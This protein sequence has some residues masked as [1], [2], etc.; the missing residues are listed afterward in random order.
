MGGLGS[1][2]QGSLPVIENGLQLDLRRM[3]RH[4]QF[5]PDAHLANGKLVWSYTHSGEQ[6]ANIGYSYCSTG[7]HPWFRVKYTSTP[8]GGE[9]I[10]V[11]EQFDLERFPQPFGG[12]RWY[13]I[14]PETGKRAQ[15]L[16]SP[17]GA[18]RFRSR[19]GFRVPLQYR[20]QCE[21]PTSRLIG[22]MHKVA[23]KILDAGTP[24]WRKKYRTWDFP[25]KP[26]GMHWRTY[27][28]LQER[29]EYYETASWAG[30]GS[31]L[32]LFG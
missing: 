11:D 15:C 30:I 31:R 14:C 29:W 20:S 17:P 10:S 25:P 6:I 22:Q 23:Y 16:Y 19:H 5:L 18:T 9:P 1:G 21:D 8:R 28:R 26:P 32:K 24:E 2:R 3:R 13:F 27:N 4:G 12:H 7:E